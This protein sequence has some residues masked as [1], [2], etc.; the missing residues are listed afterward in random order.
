MDPNGDD[1]VKPGDDPVEAGD[2]TFEIDDEESA[3]AAGRSGAFVLGIGGCGVRLVDAIF[4]RR[5]GEPRASFTPAERWDRIATG[6]AA[7]DSDLANLAS[8]RYAAE[9]VDDDPEVIGENYV[10]GPNSSGEIGE[11]AADRAVRNRLAEAGS[12]DEAWGPALR[13]EG[14]RDAASIWVLHGLGNAT[15][16]GATPTVVRAIR[17]ELAGAERTPSVEKPIVSVPVVPDLE[18]PPTP[19]P[20]RTASVLVG[21]ARIATTASAVIP[22]GN[23]RLYGH[24]HRPRIDAVDESHPYHEHNE[25]VVEFLETTLSV[26]QAAPD[27]PGGTALPSMGA[28]LD[29]TSLFAPVDARGASATAPVLAP[30]VGEVST[31]CGAESVEFLL[32]DALSRGRLIEFDPAPSSGGLLFF[33]GPKEEME[34]LDQFVYDGTIYGRMR[35]SFD[36]SSP[37]LSCTRT[38]VSGTDSVRVVVLCWNPRLPLVDELYERAKR[39]RIADDGPG[40]RLR[41]HWTEIERL[42][43]ALAPES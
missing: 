3:V 28:N 40:E 1:R 8:T 21:L 30:A 34:S 26:L 16:S 10:I 29:V 5:E 35:E 13:S 22:M 18:E 42:R 38:V 6:Y 27:A 7:I 2:A 23:D 41:E 19:H 24:P 33:S 39:H 32:R 14:L 37:H 12:F 17:E 4:L 20:A 43:E 11:P 9:W 36:R 15:G 25:T 31:I